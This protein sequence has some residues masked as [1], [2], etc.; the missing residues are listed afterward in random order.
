MAQPKLLLLDEPLLGLSPLMQAVLVR[1]TK[2]IRE[3]KKISI[4]YKLYES[5]SGWKIYDLEIQGV[6]LIRTY[7]SQFDSVLRNG[8][9]DDLILKL[10]TH[11]IDPTTPSTDSKQST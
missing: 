11:E 1:A 9:I 10:E 4:I 6:S 5:G 3:E 8:T 7:R 2:E